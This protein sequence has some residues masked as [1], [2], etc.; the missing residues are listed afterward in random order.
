MTDIGSGRWRAKWRLLQALGGALARPL[1]SDSRPWSD[2]RALW[3]PP[4]SL[5]S[6]A[7]AISQGGRPRRRGRV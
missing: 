5:E 4:E 3:T 1:P 2:H 7:A 6:T